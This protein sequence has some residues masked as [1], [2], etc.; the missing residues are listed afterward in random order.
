MAKSVKE[1]PTIAQELE[2]RRIKKP[3]AVIYPLL[4][5]IW[6]LL[7]FKKLNVHVEYKFDHKK[8]K[9]AYIAVAN[10]AS[11]MDYI[12]TGI[13]LLPHRLNYVAGYNEFFRSHLAFVFKLLQV[14]PKRNFVPDV[15]AVREIMRIIKSGGRVML[16]PEGM[17]SISGAN[18]PVAL[19]SGKLIKS[20]KVPVLQIKIKGGYLT[21]T[22][23]CL[24]E[25]PGRIDIIVDLLFTPEQLESLSADEIQAKLNEALYHDDYAWNKQQRVKYKGSGRLAHNMH[26][27]LY[28]CPK[29]GSEFTMEGKG[30]CISCSHCGNAIELN[31]KYDLKPLEEGA[32]VPRTPRE[33]FD[34]QREHVKREVAKPGFMLK[35][36]VRIGVLPDHELLKEQKTSEIVGGGI[37][38]LDKTGL[39]FDGRRQGKDFKFHVDIKDLPT[40]GCCTDLSR[41]YTFVGGEFIEFYPANPVTEKWFLATEEL[42]RQNGGAWKNA[43]ENTLQ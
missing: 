16:F 40:Y 2:I 31:S 9:G 8:L 22:K 39:T 4:G 33:W 42:H 27:L 7:Y 38:T 19:G 26:M 35:E 36:D 13:P 17:S 34:M 11:R 37:L 12:Y 41:F 32:I 25:R 30:N 3:P 23:Y 43:Y 6:Q 15:H 18:Q 29:C 28:R 14:I 10:H 1:K 5:R 24:D 21:N 20:L